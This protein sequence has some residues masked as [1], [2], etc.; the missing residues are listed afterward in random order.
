MTGKRKYGQWKLLLGLA[1]SVLVLGGIQSEAATLEAT[2]IYASGEPA[3]L[4][5]RMDNIEFRLR[6]L[7][8]FEH[9]QLLDQKTAAIGPKSETDISFVDGYSLHLTTGKGGENGFPVTIVWYKNGTKLMSTGI[10]VGKS[11]PAV[12]GGPAYRK[13]NL[14]LSIELK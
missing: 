13:G 6:R 14:I 12:L 3:S 9:Y 2:L 5:R 7:F 8:K 4:D 10:K 1:L 11:K